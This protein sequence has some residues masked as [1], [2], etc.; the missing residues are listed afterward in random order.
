MFKLQL[1]TKFTN[2]KIYALTSD[3]TNVSTSDYQRVTKIHC[4][5]LWTK[6]TAEFHNPT[7]QLINSNLKPKN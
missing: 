3:I 2:T 4:P 5:E 1:C 6:K 7:A